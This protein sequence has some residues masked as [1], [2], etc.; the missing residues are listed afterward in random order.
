MICWIGSQLAQQSRTWTQIRAMCLIQE[1]LLNGE[2]EGDPGRQTRYG[3]IL[4]Q[5]IIFWIEYR[6]TA[7]QTLILKILSLPT[8]SQLLLLARS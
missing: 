5:H 4:T 6:Q 1:H 7:W 3:Q 2:G 8:M